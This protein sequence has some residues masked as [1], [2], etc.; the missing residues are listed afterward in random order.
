M[1]L[2]QYSIY[3]SLNP[4]ARILARGYVFEIVTVDERLM[5]VLKFLAARPSLITELFVPG[6]TTKALDRLDLDKISRQQLL[7]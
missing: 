5:Q 1:A 7:L 2:S 6:G 3:D 4:T